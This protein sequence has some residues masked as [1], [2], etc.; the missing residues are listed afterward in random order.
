MSKMSPEA[1]NSE[2][3]ENLSQIPKERQSCF[4]KMFEK[5]DD[6]VE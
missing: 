2:L 6:Q 4:G 3:F 5:E 1:K